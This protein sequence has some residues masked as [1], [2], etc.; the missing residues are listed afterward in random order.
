M[1]DRIG[2]YVKMKKLLQQIFLLF[3]IF[4]SSSNMVLAKKSTIAAIVNGEAIL[5]SDLNHRIELVLSTA[6]IGNGPEVRKQIQEQILKS[7]IN[8]S[9][10][11]QTSDQFKIDVSD[12]EINESINRIASQNN[13]DIKQL[14]TLLKSINVPKSVLRKQ[15]QA[16]LAWRQYINEKYLHNIQVS[17]KDIKLFK[18]SALKERLEDLYHIKEI[19]FP[20]GDDS[21]KS[22]NEASQLSEQL[23]NGANFESIANQISRSSSALNGGDLGFLRESQLPKEIYNCVRIF[24]NG[25]V[26]R[27]I[28]I[29]NNYHIIKLKEKVVGGEK[30][31]ETFITFMQAILELPKNGTQADLEKIQEE[32]S[33][34]VTTAKTASMFKKMAKHNEKLKVRTATNI[35]IRGVHPDLLEILLSQPMGMLSQPLQTPE[36]M[37]IFSL[38]DKKV[39]KEQ[40]I[41]DDMIRSKLASERLNLFADMNI[42]KLRQHSYIEKRI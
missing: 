13:M 31:Q 15:L 21:I 11:R 4:I 28:K 40:E 17:E 36:G 22:F 23:N 6:K 2:Y 30:R 38:E 24:Q 35:A 39:V 33:K 32:S 25:Q 8:E 37:M 9:L 7:M 16:Q 3:I 27:P 26:S 12:Q 18:K 10:M 19:V 34:L 29:G 42:K 5:F 20:C 1:K 41:N 14:E